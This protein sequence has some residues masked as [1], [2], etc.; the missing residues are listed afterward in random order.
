MFGVGGMK[1]E[2][3]MA[4]RLE[5]P[6]VEIDV[7]PGEA[8]KLIDATARSTVPVAILSSA[9]F[10]ATTVNPTSVKLAG[11]PITKGKGTQWARG[12]LSDVNGDGRLVL[13]DYLSVYSLHLVAGASDALLS[14]VTFDGKS[15][16]GSQQVSFNPPVVQ[17]QPRVPSAP[18]SGTFT[19]YAECGHPV[20]TPC[21]IIINDATQ[22]VP[23]NPPTPGQAFRYPS[24]IAVAGQGAVTNL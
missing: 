2:P 13:I 12:V 11:A 24:S 4:N 3:S 5:G 10:D 6:R 9:D 1:Y 19:N 16:S 8:S 15:V 21:P 17:K 14:A 7:L 20:G 18:A 23:P 22:G